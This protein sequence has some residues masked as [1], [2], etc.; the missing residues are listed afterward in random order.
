MKRMKLFLACA[1]TLA[2]ERQ[3]IRGRRNGHFG[4]D[5][6]RPNLKSMLTEFVEGPVLRLKGVQQQDPSDSSCAPSPWLC[7]GLRQNSAAGFL[8]RIRSRD[9]LQRRCSPRLPLEFPG[10]PWVRRSLKLIVMR[11]SGP[12]LD[13]SSP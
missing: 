11:S 12:L 1:I 6:V 10:T 2:I 7:R 13:G 9:R 4:E 5:N 8:R 3:K